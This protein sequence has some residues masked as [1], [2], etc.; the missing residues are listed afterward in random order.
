MLLR[1]QIIVSGAVAALSASTLAWAED[2]QSDTIAR[3]KQSIV[4]LG[5]YQ[6]T[7]NPRF[8]FLGTGFAVG[9]G[10]LIATNAHAIHVRSKAES[11]NPSWS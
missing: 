5:T 2:N 6:A 10:S 1:R 8:R 7:R 11:K 4:V 9:N 3:V